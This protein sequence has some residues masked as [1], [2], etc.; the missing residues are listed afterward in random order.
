MATEVDTVITRFETEATQ[1]IAETQKMSQALERAGH[2]AEKLPPAA[3]KADKAVA[4]LGEKMTAFAR[5]E[6][7]EGRTAAFFV[8]QLEAIAPR[9]SMAANVLGELTQSLIGGVGLGLALGVVSMGL[10]AIVGHFE[11]AAKAEKAFADATIKAAD[12]ALSKVR[13]LH[14]ATTGRAFGTQANSP[15]AARAQIMEMEKQLRAAEAAFA[16]KDNDASKKAVE[17]LRKKIGE[18]RVELVGLQA[19]FLAAETKA[20]NEQKQ[21]EKKDRDEKT[22]REAEDLAKVLAQVRLDI[23]RNAQRTLEDFTKASNKVAADDLRARMSQAARELETMFQDS[24]GFSEPGAVNLPKYTE[25][26]VAQ[27]RYELAVLAS[28]K[29]IQKS[30]EDM[31]DSALRGFAGDVA[32]AFG[33]AIRGSAAYERAMRASG[34]ASE[35]SADLSA[36][37]FAAFTQ[38]AIASVAERAAAE[39][40]YEGAMGLAALARSF[41]DP[42]AGAEAGMHFAAAGQFAAVAAI[43]GGAASAI[44]N[45][46]GMTRAERQSVDAANAGGSSS[47]TGA[48]GGGGAGTTTQAGTT[49]TREVIVVIGDPFETPAET[50]RR[51][52]RR[53]GLAAELNMVPARSA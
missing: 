9:G 52:A 7:T 29:R 10:K 49:H 51:A 25:A 16:K 47:T 13:Q 44:G 23:E 33:Q 18:A 35:A 32:G 14:D 24:M 27:A 22:K 21:K 46:R 53:L 38:N 39:A 28:N 43:A 26:E 19:A 48:A 1:A 40:I 11:E 2:A 8:S 3:V 37:A 31:G 42:T 15:A 41:W 17:E 6:R 5:A 30:F 34:K 36:A 4:S 12:E 20:F 45:T 50:A